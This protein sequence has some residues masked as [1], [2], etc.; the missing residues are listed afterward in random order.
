MRALIIGGNRY[1]GPLLAKRLLAEGANVTMLTRGHHDDGLGNAIERIK[2]DRKDAAGLKP[3]LGDR[4][5]DAV[6]DQVCY[7][8]GEAEE[9]CEIFAER[10]PLYVMTSTISV[11]QHGAEIPEQAFEPRAYSFDQAVATKADYGKAKRQA[12]SVFFQKAKFRVI[13]PRFP[14]ICGPNDPT[15]RLKFHIDRVKANEAV[16]FPNPAAKM[17]FI[18]ST[19]A[20]GCLLGL[21]RTSFA[22]PIN[23]SSPDAIAMGDLMNLIGEIVGTRPVVVTEKGKGADSPYGITADYYPSVRTLQSLGIQTAKL[24]EWMPG[25]IRQLSGGGR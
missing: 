14:V 18:S 6:F 20:A 4:L 17:S 8:A 15:S 23:C 16:H 21:A 19:D 13:A 24:S 7:E 11:Y 12:E 2:C 22:G 9:A 10:T 25:L 5:W 3:A 1:V